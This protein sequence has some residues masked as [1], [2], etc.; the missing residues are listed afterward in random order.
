MRE[1]G[2]SEAATV[3][4]DG[5]TSAAEKRR[6]RE[7]VKAALQ[8]IDAAFVRAGS[9]RISDEDVQAVVE[10]ADAIEAR[11]RRD[12]PL[13]RFLDDGRLLL[14]LVKDYWHG[15]YRQVPYW[16]LAA[17]A[18]VLLYV[19]NPLDLIPDALPGIGLVDDAAVLS[20]CLLMIEQDLHEYR[21]WSARRGE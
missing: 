4:S 8:K 11:L 3:D 9:R 18:F 16:T 15:A 12:G 6:M 2:Q 17:V 20:V 1:P 5:K 21:G 13:G 14:A 19:A 7:R 10:K